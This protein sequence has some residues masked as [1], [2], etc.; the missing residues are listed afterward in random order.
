MLYKGG[1]EVAERYRRNLS[2]ATLQPNAW[3]PADTD[4]GR[5]N[6]AALQL[7]RR[8]T[9]ANHNCLHQAVADRVRAEAPGLDIRFHPG[10]IDPSELPSGYKPAAAVVRQIKVDGL[11]ATE[12]D[13]D[14][15]GC[16][17]AGDVVPVWLKG[18]RQQR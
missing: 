17:M 6:W 16:I 7:I 14:P 3:I 2:P 18:K 13:I 15:Y 9:K 11:A 10:G 8:W 12:D 1:I 4:D 5:D